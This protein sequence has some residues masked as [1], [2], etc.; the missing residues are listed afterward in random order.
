MLYLF[1]R[2]L[3]RYFSGEIRDFFLFIF[4]GIIL[5]VDY[6]FLMRVKVKRFLV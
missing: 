6:V 5:L 1:N 3:R 4:V 2:V